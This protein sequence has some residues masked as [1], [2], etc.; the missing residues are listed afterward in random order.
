[1]HDCASLGKCP[2]KQW[3]GGTRSDLGSIY[4]KVSK[5]VVAAEMERR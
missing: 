5:T 3:K 4:K 2:G 1:M